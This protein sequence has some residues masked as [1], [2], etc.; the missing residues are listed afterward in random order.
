MASCR[1]LLLPQDCA[2]F[3][4]KALVSLAQVVSSAMSV[5]NRYA[6]CSVTKTVTMLAPNRVSVMEKKRIF[7]VQC[8]TDVT[9]TDHTRGDSQWW[10][11]SGGLLL[12]Q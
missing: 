2:K 11:A 1:W 9:N 5:T 4:P 10:Q 7:C 12:T 8:I 3:A 6:R